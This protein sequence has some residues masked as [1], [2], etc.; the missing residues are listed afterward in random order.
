MLV[1]GDGASGAARRRGERRL[2]SWWGHEAQSVQEAVVSALH[3]NHHNHH[4]AFPSSVAARA[5]FLSVQAKLSTCLC[6]VTAPAEPPGGGLDDA[7]ARGGDTSALHHSRDVGPA[8]YEALRGQK[9]TT[10]VEEAGLESHSSLRAPTP[11]PPGMRPASLAEPPGAQE[12]LQR[13]TVEQL[14]DGA[15]RLPALAADGGPAR[16]RACSLRLAHSRAGH[17][18]A[19]DF[20]STPLFAHCSSLTAG[21]GTVG[22]SAS[23]LC[24]RGHDHGTVRG[25]CWPHVV[26]D[27]QAGWRVHVVV[28]GYKP[29]PGDLPGRDHRQ[30]RA[31]YKYWAPRRWLIPGGHARQV[32]AVADRQGGAL[33]VLP[34][35]GGH[36][37]GAAV[38]GAVWRRRQCCKL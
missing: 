32:P 13:H 20:V 14:A 8:K 31:V 27:L 33:P 2:R 24:P 34:Q 29:P 22:G 26:L 23:A 10:E 11:L 4:M 5:C 7:C 18:S 16:G 1:H 37:S 3:H 17:R 21:G 12:R 38:S 25:H 28:G 30:P 15:P 36:S 35:S 9:K 6:M 19:Q